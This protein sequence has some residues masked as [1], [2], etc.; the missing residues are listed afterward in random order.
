MLGIGARIRDRRQELGLTQSRLAALT[1]LSRAT[2]N[3]L[4]AGSTDLGVAKVLT[5]AEVLGM[6]LEMQQRARPGGRWLKAA[7]ASASVSYRKPL[8]ESELVRAIKT[9]ELSPEFVPHIATLL[10]EASPSLLVRT[11]SDV[12]PD[13]IPKSAWTNL[14]E[15]GKQTMVSRRHLR[16]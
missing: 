15:L 14:V 3:A 7:V 8:P 13:G 1:D 2:I 9:G 4:E 16:P 11:L 10:E 12:F 6:T 5:I